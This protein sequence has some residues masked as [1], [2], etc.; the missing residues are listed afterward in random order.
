L[1]V[2]VGPE[3]PSLGRHRLR[4]LFVSSPVSLSLLWMTP[5]P[6]I[7]WINAEPLCCCT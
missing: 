6:L 1:V 4:R 3:V 7:V 5:L 2:A